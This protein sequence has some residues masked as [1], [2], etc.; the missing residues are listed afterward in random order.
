MAT[1][2]YLRGCDDQASIEASRNVTNDEAAMRRNHH[3]MS[4][5]LW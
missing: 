2:L 5:R 3:D 1:S 4:R